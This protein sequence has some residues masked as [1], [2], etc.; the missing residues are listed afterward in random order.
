MTARHSDRRLRDAAAAFAAFVAC[1]FTEFCAVDHRHLTNT[2][3]GSGDLSGFGRFA[4]DR[5]QQGM[6]LD[7]LRASEKTARVHRQ[8][9]S[10]EHNREPIQISQLRLSFLVE[11]RTQAGFTN[12]NNIESFGKRRR[13]RQRKPL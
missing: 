4:G 11:R 9:V 3:H 6:P 1:G 10:S 8:N 5:E 2:G 7:S 12:R 13:F